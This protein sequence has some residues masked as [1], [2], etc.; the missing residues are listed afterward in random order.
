MT[1]HWLLTT[2]NQG[3]QPTRSLP[4][5]VELPLEP[6]HRPLLPVALILGSRF[7]SL[8]PGTIQELH[9]CQSLSDHG[10]KNQAKEDTAN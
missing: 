6:L 4:H 3:E 2:Q 7:W 5:P 9:L 10:G 1:V 8:P